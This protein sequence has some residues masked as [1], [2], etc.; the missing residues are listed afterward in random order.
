MRALLFVLLLVPALSLA[1]G[2]STFT[3][4]ITDSECADAN[5]GRMR[6][7]ETD[8]ECVLACV[9]AHAASY[10]LRD[11]T[12]TYQLTD[13]HV[14]KAF[15]GKRVRVTGMLNEKTKTITVQSIAA[16]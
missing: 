15:A 5:H 8:A 6:M 16:L 3:G 2:T 11:A 1:Q 7:G 4:T 14:P 10:V 12:E 13:Q 9:D